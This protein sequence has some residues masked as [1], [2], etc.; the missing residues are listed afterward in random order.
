MKYTFIL[1]SLLASCTP[2]S[3]NSPDSA[4]VSSIDTANDHAGENPSLGI[5]GTFAVE[6]EYSD[7]SGKAFIALTVNGA[8]AFTFK[9]YFLPNDS[10]I[11]YYKQ[12][13]GTIVRNNDTVVFNVTQKTC[14]FRFEGKTF[15]F[16]KMS[17]NKIKLNFEG[18]FHILSLNATPSVSI[19][20]A[21]EDVNCAHLARSELQT[22]RSPA[23]KK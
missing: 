8:N 23:S 18:G 13:S 4:L 3:K 6:G 19:S 12:A 5:D 1:F 10:G 11:I 16:L 21:I 17:A 2:N 9:E 20:S 14:N 15:T 7:F 22:N